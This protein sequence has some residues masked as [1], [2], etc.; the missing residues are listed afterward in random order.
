MLDEQSTQISE[1]HIPNDPTEVESPTLAQAVKR[2]PNVEIDA[3]HR[4]FLEKVM[5]EGGLSDP[6]DAR[7]L[8]EV[9]YRIMRDLM[10]ADQIDRVTDELHE[11]VLVTKDKTLQM[12]I[13]DLW[14]DTNPIVGFLSRVRQPLNGPGLSGI[15]DEL[16]IAR[17]TSEGGIGPDVDPETVIRAVFAATKPELSAERVQEVA[18]CLPSKVR[19]LWEQA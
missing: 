15:N 3:A 13:A 11:E 4:P 16:F 2:D 18:A 7:D 12:E 14:K 17:V 9:V 5:L 19:A 6:Y 10:T 8:T 1:T